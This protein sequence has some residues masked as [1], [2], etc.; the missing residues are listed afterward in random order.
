MVYFFFT[1]KDVL[2]AARTLSFLLLYFLCLP[3][4]LGWLVSNARPFSL[5]T[6]LW[7]GS[8]ST[9]GSGTLRAMVRDMGAYIKLE[10]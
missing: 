9:V 10:H 1:A 8:V 7:G 2:V 6:R 4:A 5:G 3:P